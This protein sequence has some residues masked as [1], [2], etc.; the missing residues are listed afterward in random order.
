VVEL[1]GQPTSLQELSM[2]AHRLTNLKFGLIAIVALLLLPAC[3]VNVKKG[4]N[5]QDKNV[6][7]HTPVGDIKVDKGADARDTGLAVYPGARIR[8]D[9]NDNDSKSANVNLSFGEYGLKVVALEYESDDKPDKIVSFYQSELKKYGHVLE[10][11]V[12]SHGGHV[13]TDSKNDSDDLKCEDSGGTT[14]ELKVGTKQNQ[15]IV[16][17]EAQNKGSHFALVRVQTHGKDTI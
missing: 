4:E 5:G 12:H 1:I 8:H 3:S 2:R 14:I 15:R 9:D 13:E 11:H 7:I 17:V 16:S 6:D 10:C